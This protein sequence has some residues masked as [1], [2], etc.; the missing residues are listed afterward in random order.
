MNEKTVQAETFF[1]KL[2][3][4]KEAQI[5]EEIANEA[6][7]VYTRTYIPYVVIDKEI[8]KEKLENIKKKMGELL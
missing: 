2:P 1:G 7:E 8:V 6:E 4:E 3:S 5:V